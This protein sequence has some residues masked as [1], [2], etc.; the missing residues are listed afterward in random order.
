MGP[1]TSNT[2]RASL[3]S[4]E[5]EL[6]GRA[7]VGGVTYA[8]AQ[9]GDRPG[10]ARAR[11]AVTHAIGEIKRRTDAEDAEDAAC[12]CDPNALRLLRELVQIAVES[13]YRA[14]REAGVLS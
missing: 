13:A 4:G 10:R 6:I 1:S 3:T 12:T 8:H 2:R 11:L 5:R 9:W 14:L 7:A